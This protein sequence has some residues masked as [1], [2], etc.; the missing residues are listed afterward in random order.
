MLIAILSLPVFGADSLSEAKP[1]T[2]QEL[3]HLLSGNTMNGLWAGRPYTQYFSATGSTRYREQ[4][5]PETSGRWRVN[6][7]GQYCSVWPP[8]DREACYKVLVNGAK[9]YWESGDD[10]YPADVEKGFHF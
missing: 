4:D 2:Q 6:Q 5:G 9:I 10:I 1:P 7:Q 8:S 3:S